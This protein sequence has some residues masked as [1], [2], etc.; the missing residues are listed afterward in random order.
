MNTIQLVVAVRPNWVI[1]ETELLAK[2]VTTLSV[3]D[4]DGSVRACWLT[5]LNR[6][7]VDR[8]T[9][10]LSVPDSFVVAEAGTIYYMHAKATV[11]ADV[12]T[13][14]KIERLVP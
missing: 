11:V 13:L 14:T 12:V 9:V 3:T 1:P 10:T 4:G 7:E 5:N 2:A 8:L 6:P